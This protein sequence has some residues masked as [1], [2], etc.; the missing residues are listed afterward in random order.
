MNIEENLRDFA[1][2]YNLNF[3]MQIFD[4]CYGRHMD[5]YAYSLYNNFGCF[6]IHYLP[7]RGEIE[8]FVSN[9]FSNSRKDLCCRQVN[10]FETE[11]NVWRQKEKIWVF[12]NPFYYWSFKRYVKTLIEVMRLSIQ[13]RKEFFGIKIE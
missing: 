3:C 5:A 4:N 2:A 8:C 11:A 7:V 10:V 6:T 12:K 13:K 1:K 9:Q